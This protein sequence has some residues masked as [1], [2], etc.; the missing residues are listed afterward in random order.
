MK[1]SQRF[2]LMVL[3]M[4]LGLPVASAGVTSLELVTTLPHPGID[5]YMPNKPNGIIFR[6]R[7]HVPSDFPA[8][9]P[10]TLPG[11]GLQLELAE[12]MPTKVGK[13]WLALYRTAYGDAKQRFMIHY[14]DGAGVVIASTQIWHDREVQDMRYDADSGLLFYNVG[15]AGTATA[16]KDN[17]AML[18]AWDPLKNRTVWHSDDLVSNDVFIVHDD[19]II[20]GYGFSGEADFLYVIDKRTGE[21]RSEVLLQ[22]AHDHLLVKDGMLE[23]ITYKRKLVFRFLH[24]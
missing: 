22:T 18:V 16:L 17:A 13:H 24:Q 5:K 15:T 1:Q 20:S 9:A 11:I 8:L 23:V 10:R 6:S 3:A 12:P 2:I 7:K 19:V 4:M 14:M 21:T